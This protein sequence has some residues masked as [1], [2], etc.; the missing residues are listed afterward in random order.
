MRVKLNA[1]GTREK[2][3]WKKKRTVWRCS[4]ASPC[5]P[6]DA[7]EASLQMVSRS[8]LEISSAA[9]PL[10]AFSCECESVDNEKQDYL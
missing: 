2:N 1:M 4:R 7:N 5:L 10:P 3:K 8:S 6:P 9:A